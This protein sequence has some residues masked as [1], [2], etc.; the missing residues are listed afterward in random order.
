MASLFHFFEEVFV[1]NKKV[2]YLRVL[3]GKQ[4][5]FLFCV[6]IQFKMKK[7]HIIKDTLKYSP[8]FSVVL[9]CK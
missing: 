8:A 9:N 5:I 3:R 1:D 4:L 2:L 6:M 7:I